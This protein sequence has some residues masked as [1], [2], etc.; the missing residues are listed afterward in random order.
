MHF[1]QQF[2]ETSSNFILDFE[3]ELKKS[4]IFTNFI[5]FEEEN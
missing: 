4:L 5:R 3:I 2:N 1:S